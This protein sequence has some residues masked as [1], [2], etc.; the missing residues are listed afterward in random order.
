MLGKIPGMKQLAAANRLRDAVKTGGFEGNPMMSNLADQLLEAAV[1]EQGGFGPG[2]PGP[3]RPVD[4]G[5]KKSKRKMQR[6]SR[7]KSRR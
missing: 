4:K 7:R 6:K 3:K 2:G 5:K 1:A